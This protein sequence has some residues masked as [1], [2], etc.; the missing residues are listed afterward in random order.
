MPLNIS[1]LIVTGT[2]TSASYDYE[3]RLVAKNES[4]DVSDIHFLKGSAVIRFQ[5]KHLVNPIFCNTWWS[6]FDCFFDTKG[7][8]KH[9]IISQIFI[10]DFL[11]KF[12]SFFLFHIFTYIESNVSI[13]TLIS[14][15]IVYTYLENFN[16]I[17]LTFYN[18][19]SC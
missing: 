16:P 13:M 14:R 17:L 6:S 7:V 9:E 1:I 10:N 15:Y 19:V 18:I 8:S 12:P 3:L 2:S 11:K 4:A 5:K